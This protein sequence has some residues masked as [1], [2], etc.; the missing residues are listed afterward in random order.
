MEKLKDKI[1]VDTG[2]LLRNHFKNK[3]FFKVGLSES[4][5]VN[6]QQIAYYLKCK[7]IDVNKLI[8]FSFATKHNFLLDIALK[9]PKDFGVLIADDKMKDNEIIHLKEQIRILEIE[10]ENIQKKYNREVKYQNS[11]R[12]NNKS[13]VAQ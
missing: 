8:D 5:N 3:R 10:K 1:H 2:K 13:E 7:S 12:N 11:K 9:L 6:Y 4:M